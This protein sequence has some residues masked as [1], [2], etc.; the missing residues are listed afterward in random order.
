MTA[1]QIQ[2]KP[3]LANGTIYHCLRQKWRGTYKHTGYNAGDEYA[4]EEEL[5]EQRNKRVAQK[6]AS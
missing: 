4:L 5:A 2:N 6:T 1:I 3:W